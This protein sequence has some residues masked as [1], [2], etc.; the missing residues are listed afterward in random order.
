LLS[1]LTFV[2]P[3]TLN[4]IPMLLLPPPPWPDYELLDTGNFEKMERFGSYV[5]S[6]PEPQAVWSKGLPEDEWEKS[7]HARFKK[8]KH[9]PEKG[10]WVLK[11]NMP[12]QWLINY[13]Y[14]ELKIRM[15][16]G[17]TAFKHVGVFPE[18]AAN[19]DYIHQSVKALNIKRP[20]V[21]NLFAYTGGASLAACAAG[22]EVVHV[23]SVKPVITWAKQ[24]MAASGLD[25]IRWI[26][27]D[28]LKFVKRE[29]R[30]GNLYDGIIL[31]PP[32]YGRGPEGEKWVLEDQ[33]QEMMISCQHLLTPASSFLLLNAYS[34][35]LSAL[36]LESLVKSLFTGIQNLEFGELFI[37]DRLGRKL[38][39]GIFC[40]FS[41]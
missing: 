33:I 40:R 14:G 18:Q 28:A 17:L 35:G 12:D 25:G 11:E 2:I 29:V 10:E 30:R 16:L 20:R 5:I 39:L 19:W 27:D 7:C 8:D 6:R 22:A 36:I 21:L 24:N 15:R 41:K 4:T 31:D 9:N 37:P 26:V 1:K 13:E 23:D 3:V 32:A 38:P 34:M